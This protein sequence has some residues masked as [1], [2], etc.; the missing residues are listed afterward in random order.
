MTQSRIFSII[1]P[2]FFCDSFMNRKFKRTLFLFIFYSVKVFT[3]IDQMNVSL[4]NKSIF[5][6]IFFK[7]KKTFWL[8]TF[9][10]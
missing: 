6:N 7:K 10:W 1:T 9:E 3:V 2:V 8:Q 4:L 5:L